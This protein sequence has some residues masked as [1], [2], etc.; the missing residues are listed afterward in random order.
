MKFVLH[1]DRGAGIVK[2]TVVHWGAR[3]G[4]KT[5]TTNYCCRL[6]HNSLDLLKLAAVLPANN[7]DPSEYIG[8][9]MVFDR[10]ARAYPLLKQ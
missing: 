10:E 6:L 1:K 3:T 9:S 2:W 8:E 7:I 4:R 5:L